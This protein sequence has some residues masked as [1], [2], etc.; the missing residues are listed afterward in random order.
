MSQPGSQHDLTIRY[1]DHIPRRILSLVYF[2]AWCCRHLAH[3]AP[4]NDKIVKYNYYISFFCFTCRHNDIPWQLRK[5]YMNRMENVTLDKNNPEFHTDIPRL[6]KGGVGAQVSGL[7]SKQLP[8]FQT[9]PRRPRQEM[10]MRKKE[11]ETH[12]EPFIGQGECVLI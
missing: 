1:W 3:C 6:R 8:R 4:P 10:R 7:E 12:I 9:R 11:I 2:S 5:N